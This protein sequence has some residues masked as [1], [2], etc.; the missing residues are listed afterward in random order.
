LK[1]SVV[2]SKAIHFPSRDHVGDPCHRT[3]RALT[4]G[5]GLDPSGSITQMAGMPRLMTFFTGSASSGA[6]A[7]T[8]ARASEA[9]RK[10]VR[11]RMGAGENGTCMA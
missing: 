2:T 3:P 8:A 6:A 7:P 5:R 10:H 1:P 9:A 11:Q 4:S